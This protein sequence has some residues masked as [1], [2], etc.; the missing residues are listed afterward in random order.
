MPHIKEPFTLEDAGAGI[1]AFLGVLI[2]AQPP[3]LFPRHDP[4]ATTLTINSGLLPPPPVT[5]H[6]RSIAV[7]CALL[8]SFAAASA[9]ATI[10][11]I[12]KRASSLVSVNYF[13]VLATVSSFLI[14]VI[15]PDLQFE[16]PR[17]PGQWYV[18]ICNVILSRGDLG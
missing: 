1:L 10:R 12:G 7:I 15:H 17:T 14:I 6:Q 3:F 9:Y 5:P 8:G 18:P 4:D 2:I 16:I 11:V 13:A